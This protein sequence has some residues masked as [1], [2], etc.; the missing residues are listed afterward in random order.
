V[1]LQPV[2]SNE[3][4]DLVYARLA[5]LVEAHRTTLVFRQHA[6]DGRARCQAT[7]RKARQGCRAAHTTQPGKGTALWMPNND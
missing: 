2:M 1:P 4:W 6:P 3:Q 5:E 7:R